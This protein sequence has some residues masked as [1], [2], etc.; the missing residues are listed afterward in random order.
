MENPCFENKKKR[1]KMTIPPKS[2]YKRIIILIYSPNGIFMETE[3][4]TLKSTRNDKE[5][6]KLR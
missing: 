2:A 5:F 6:Y 4:L 1:K 3:T